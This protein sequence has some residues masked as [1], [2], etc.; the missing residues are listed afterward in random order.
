MNVREQE[1]QLQQESLDILQELTVY[2]KLS[3]HAQKLLLLFLIVYRKPR[4]NSSEV[5]KYHGAKHIYELI[6]E[7]AQTIKKLSGKIFFSINYPQYLKAWKELEK[8]GLIERTPIYE[9]LHKNANAYNE[10]KNNPVDN[11]NEIQTNETWKTVLRP[12]E[13]G[14]K[15]AKTS[16]NKSW[17]VVFFHLFEFFLIG[18]YLTTEKQYL[19]NAPLLQSISKAIKERNEEIK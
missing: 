16:Q 5:K 1:Q 6:K 2:R 4:I 13:K 8:A 3:I 14:L 9:E 12:T 19:A 17:N 7:E 15:I 11:L 18:G 10:I